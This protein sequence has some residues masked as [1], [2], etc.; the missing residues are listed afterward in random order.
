[1]KTGLSALRFGLAVGF[2][3]AA[4]ITI[5][6]TLWELIE[7]PGGIFRGPDGINWP[8]V[9][10]TVT[11]WFIPTFVIITGAAALGHLIWILI[12]RK[13]YGTAKK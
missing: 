6:I 11:S 12:R 13:H 4:L 1:M 5:I 9:F 3:I 10:E 2:S 8:F 7:N